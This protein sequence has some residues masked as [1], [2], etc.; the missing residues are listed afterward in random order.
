MSPGLGAPDVNARNGERIVLNK[1]MDVGCLDAETLAAWVGG[2]LPAVE[3]AAAEAH[4]ADCARCQA[5]LA[6]MIRTEPESAAVESWWRT[7]PTLRWLAP[8]TAAAAAALLWVAVDRPAPGRS[9]A[10]F[11]SAAR[12]QPQQKADAPAEPPANLVFRDEKK[13][14]DVALEERSSLEARRQRNETPQTR[15]KALTP[16]SP[17][18]AAA[19][20]PPA[21]LQEAVTDSL[22]K[23]GATDI[24][25]P[26]GSTRWRVGARGQV[27]RSTDGGAHWEPQRSGTTSD[28]TAGAAP[29]SSV[30]WLVGA[31]GTVLLT[32]DGERWQRLSFPVAI[33]LTSVA[34]TDARNATVTA[35]DGRTFT[36]RDG[37]STWQQEL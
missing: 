22:R 29:S 8:L 2:G 28:L 14:A 10:K 19:P 33:D 27:E 16:A 25:S 3:R 21:A 11:E 18:A 35:A 1:E 30:A 20:P 9:D 24:A 5:L 23:A 32:T 4:A 15:E 12:S 17:A 31:A 34:A 13:A 6:A 26:G 7:A 37:G 36:T